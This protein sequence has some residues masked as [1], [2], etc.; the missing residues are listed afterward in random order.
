MATTAEALSTSYSISVTLPTG[1]SIVDTTVGASAGIL[2]NSGDKVLGPIAAG[3]SAPVEVKGLGMS[4]SITSG[5]GVFADPLSV[6]NGNI[7]AGGV[8]VSLGASVSGTQTALSGT[9]PYTTTWSVTNS[10]TSQGAIALANNAIA[11]PT[12]GTYDGVV[13]LP[14]SS[15][16]LQSGTYF[17]QSLDLEPGA[18]LFVDS[19]QGPVFLYVINS[20]LFRGNEI[21]ADSG[22]PELFLAFLGT[23]EVDLEAPFNGVFLAPNAPLLHMEDALWVLDPVK[24][25]RGNT[26]A[27]YSNSIVVDAG[28][29]I[30]P[31][32]FNWTTVPG[33]PIPPG[34]WAANGGPRGSGTPGSGATGGGGTGTGGGVSQVITKTPTGL[35]LVISVDPTNSATN[36]ATQTS[37]TPITYT[38]PSSFDVGGELGNNTVTLSCSNGGTTVT[39]TYR[40]GSPTSNPTAVLDLEAGRT[41]NFVSCTD[42]LPANTPRVATSCT[43]TANPL[44]NYP[45][46]I[47]LPLDDNSCSHRFDIL[48][49]Y[50]TRQMHDSFAWPDPK[51]QTPPLVQDPNPDGT[52]A[53]YY[54]WVYVKSAQDILSLRKLYVHMLTRPLFTQEIEPYTGKCGVF[55]NPGD[56]TGMFVPVLMPGTVYNTLLNVQNS[57]FQGAPNNLK[58]D[59][60]NNVYF[61]AVILRNNDVPA[62]ARNANGSINFQ[63]LKNSGFRYLSYESLPLPTQDSMQLNAST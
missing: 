6:V 36:T 15:L 42:G 30:K 35:P 45:L 25:P 50:Q 51:L 17:F 57:K 4:G 2:L 47:N 21:G 20:L 27:F 10:G 61:D 48:T 56:G 8:I 59:V 12:P 33:M 26:G 58:V 22:K 1:T 19:R 32:T 13:V 23:C 52:P 9:R 14:G 5:G 40:G 24:Q 29:I 43:L 41:A 39:C 62:S 37:A 31:T 63:T 55:Q 11:A 54:A 18:N 38:L 46:T 16:Y 3:G 60:N 34:G 7:V 53:L 49:P 28:E 44:P